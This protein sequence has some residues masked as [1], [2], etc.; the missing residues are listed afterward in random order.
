[1]ETLNRNVCVGGGRARK[2]HRPLAGPIPFPHPQPLQ[3][4]EAVAARRPQHFSA[5]SVRCWTL[6]Y[7]TVGTPL[8]RTGTGQQAFPAPRARDIQAVG[9]PVYHK[10]LKFDGAAVLCTSTG[11]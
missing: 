6:C 2:T 5:N 7:R 3:P 4:V 10:Q 11:E 9:V 1:M 8:V